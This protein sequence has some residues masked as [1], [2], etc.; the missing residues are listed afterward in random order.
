VSAETL[1]AAAVLGVVAGALGGALGVGT[2]VLVV[3]SLVLVFGLNQTAA[4]GTSL[5][6]VLV[7]ASVGAFANYR[8]GNLRSWLGVGIGGVGAVAA[9][10]GTFLALRLPPGRLTQAFAV[11]LVLIGLHTLSAVCRAPAAT[12]GQ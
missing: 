7:N 10:G 1:A 8:A 2:G 11:Y 5:L 6:V 3:P 9:V 12:N 4:E